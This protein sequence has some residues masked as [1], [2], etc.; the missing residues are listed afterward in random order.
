[1]NIRNFGYRLFGLNNLLFIEKF[2]FFIL[3]LMYFIF[4]I[5]YRLLLNIYMC[6]RVRYLRCFNVCNINIVDCWVIFFKFGVVFR[7]LECLLNFR[8]FLNVVVSYM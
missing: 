2:F 1:M 8:I 5:Y 6:K 4:K 7:I 3:Y